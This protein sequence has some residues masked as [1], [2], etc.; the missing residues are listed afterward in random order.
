MRVLR[1]SIRHD[2]KAPSRLASKSADGRF[3]FYVAVNGR[4]DWYDLE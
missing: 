4:R 3:D 2:D 1:E